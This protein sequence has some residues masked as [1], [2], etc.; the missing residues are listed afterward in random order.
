MKVDEITE[1]SGTIAH[2]LMFGLARR[3]LSPIEAANAFAQ[4]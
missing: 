2:E 4:G 3:V 1:A